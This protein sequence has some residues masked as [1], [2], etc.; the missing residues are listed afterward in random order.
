MRSEQLTES[1]NHHFVQEKIVEHRTDLETCPVCNGALEAVHQEVDIRIGTRS[2]SVPVD[3]QVCTDCGEAYFTPE[4][5][6]AA[7]RQAAS[8]VRRE[9]GLLQPEEIRRLRTRLKLSQTQFEILLGVGPKTVV[10]WERGYVFQN[11]ATDTLLRI[12][13]NVPDAVSFLTKLKAPQLSQSRRTLR[14]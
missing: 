9:E 13:T 4:A 3:H 10:R 1:G 14:R 2:V 11:A 6:D 8:A 5:A 12:L 7:Q